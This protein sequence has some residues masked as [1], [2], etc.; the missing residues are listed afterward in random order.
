MQELL[1]RGIG[2][3]RGAMLAHLEPPYANSRVL[4]ISERASRRSLLL[5]LDSRMSEDELNSVV[6]ALWNLAAR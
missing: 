6:A 3:R 5:P 2:V 4:P 1:D